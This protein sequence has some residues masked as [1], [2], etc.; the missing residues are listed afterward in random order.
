VID[1]SND[2]GAQEAMKAKVGD[3]SVPTIVVG[4]KIMKGF[5][6]SILEGELEAGGYPKAEA[7]DEGAP[8]QQ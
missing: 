7:V 8:P 5:M 3:L 1:V 4:S 6:E 2:I